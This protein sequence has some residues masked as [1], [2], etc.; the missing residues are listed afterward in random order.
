MRNA[1]GHQS[2]RSPPTPKKNVL[3]LSLTQA[4]PTVTV[5][6]TVRSLRTRN[7]EKMRLEL[8]QLSLPVLSPFSHSFSKTG[9]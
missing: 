4:T 6:L 1:S 5:T 9:Q 8:H 2:H 7:G 3:F